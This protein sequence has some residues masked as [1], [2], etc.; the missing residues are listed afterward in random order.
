MP[1]TPWW[2]LAQKTPHEDSVADEVPSRRQAERAQGLPGASQ[3]LQ[4][5]LRCE[6]TQD[7]VEPLLSGSRAG[8]P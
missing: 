7:P 2:S 5:P 6:R 8:S 1:L 4:E 3:L